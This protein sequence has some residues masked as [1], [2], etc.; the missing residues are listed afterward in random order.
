M[1]YTTEFTGSFKLDKALDKETFDLLIG[2]SETRR[3]KRNIEGY[4]IEGEFYVSE[5]D[6]YSQNRNPNIVDYNSPPKTQPGLWCNWA[7]NEAGTE[8]EWNGA[9]KFYNYVEWLVYLVDSILKPRR[10]LLTGVV[11]WYGEESND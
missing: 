8:I 5:R 10:Y 7:P 1:G 11:A 3:V 4:G 9:E 6:G 2:L